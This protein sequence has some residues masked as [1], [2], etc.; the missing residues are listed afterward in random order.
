MHDVVSSNYK[1]IIIQLVV[2]VLC[3]TVVKLVLSIGISETRYHNFILSNCFY[4]F[5]RNI[6]LLKE[7]K[8]GRVLE[9]LSR[10]LIY[11]DHEV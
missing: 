5:H 3:I 6:N 10:N 2:L 7:K 1:L 8:K 4:F 9:P 11:G